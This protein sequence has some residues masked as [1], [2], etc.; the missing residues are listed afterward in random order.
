MST[1]TKQVAVPN[2]IGSNIFLHRTPPP[3]SIIHAWCVW[4]S[5]CRSTIQNEP[6]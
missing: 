5:G 2:P 1:I 4:S 6:V 3:C